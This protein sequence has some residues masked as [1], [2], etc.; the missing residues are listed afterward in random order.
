MADPKHPTNP[1]WV[2][3]DPLLNPPPRGG[4]ELLLI[5]AGGVLIKGPWDDSCL[6]WCY[7]PVIPLSVKQRM[8]A[9][10]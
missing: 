2:M 4:Q 7:K 8:Y 10:R 5:N 9:P 6:A 1:D 3:E